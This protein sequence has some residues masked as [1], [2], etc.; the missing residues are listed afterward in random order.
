MSVSLVK[1]ISWNCLNMLITDVAPPNTQ[2]KIKCRFKC[3]KQNHVPFDSTS[4]LSNMQDP[5][6]IFWARH[7]MMMMMY[8]TSLRR[9]K[10]QNGK[11]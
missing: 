9:L 5:G 6:Q 8:F 11:M 2:T 1:S 4:M 7:K 3:C 10:S